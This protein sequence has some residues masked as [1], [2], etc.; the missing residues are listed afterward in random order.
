MG[1]NDQCLGCLVLTAYYVL[2][3]HKKIPL[4]YK[5]AMTASKRKTIESN[6][7]WLPSGL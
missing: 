7:P 1:K 4:I 3:Y 6:H 5:I 2:G